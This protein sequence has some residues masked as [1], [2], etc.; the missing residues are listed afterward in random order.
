MWLSGL[1]IPK[2]FQNLMLRRIGPTVIGTGDEIFRAG[3]PGC[4]KCFLRYQCSEL[5]GSVSS[6]P[7]LWTD[8]IMIRCVHRE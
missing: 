3:N 5:Q 8:G 4:P 7:V 2:Y 1:S 6:M